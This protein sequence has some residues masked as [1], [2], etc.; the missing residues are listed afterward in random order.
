MVVIMCFYL[1]V[2]FVVCIVFIIIIM[3]NQVPVWIKITPHMLIIK[4]FMM[5]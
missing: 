5:V 4:Y 1:H 3:L 2:Y